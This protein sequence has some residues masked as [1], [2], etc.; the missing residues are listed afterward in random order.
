MNNKKN[1]EPALDVVF[2]VLLIIFGIY[3]VLTS[4]GLKYFNSFIDGAGFFPCIIGS[5]L[6]LLGAVIVVP[7]GRHNAVRRVHALNY[8]A[9][10]GIAAVQMGRVVH[11]DEKLAAR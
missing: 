5:V 6:I 3:I 4:L 1:R 8:L 9:E 10:S 11:H 7:L 2:S